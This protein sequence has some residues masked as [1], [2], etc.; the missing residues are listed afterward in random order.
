MMEELKELKEKIK[1]LLDNFTSE[2]MLRRAYNHLVFLC[3]HIR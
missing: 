1:E 3:V 2:E